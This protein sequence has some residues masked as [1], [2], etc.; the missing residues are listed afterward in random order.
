MRRAKAAAR[1]GE[2]EVSLLIQAALVAG[3]EPAACETGGNKETRVVS[4][5]E[6]R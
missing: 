4:W 3:V 5:E 6:K 2:G 1:T